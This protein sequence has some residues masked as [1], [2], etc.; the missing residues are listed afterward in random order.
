M[1]TKILSIGAQ[2]LT[3]VELLIT[4]AMVG[5]V[6]AIGIPSYSDFVWRNR[7]SAAVNSLVTAFNLARSEAIKTGGRVTVCTTAD[8]NANPPV[9][10]G[11]GW[12]QGWIV[13]RDAN[14]DLTIA[15]P[16]ADILAV[17]GPLDNLFVMTG[18]GQLAQYAS[19]VGDGRS[20]QLGGGFL[21]G[22]V[23]L[24]QSAVPGSPPNKQIVMNNLGRLSVQ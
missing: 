4:V 18:N 10:G 2:G 5:L 21:A 9:C 6:L 11:A 15:D 20:R 22:T 23:T 12:H 3:L 16:A 8:P 19:Y 1:N 24:D 7:A 13:Y 14:A 17:G